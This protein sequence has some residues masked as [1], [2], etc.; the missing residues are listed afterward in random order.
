LIVAVIIVKV[1]IV[2]V[3]FV[4]V[5]FGQNKGKNKS[6]RSRANEVKNRYLPGSEHRS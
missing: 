6:L 5:V 4:V 2:V 3:I 1:A